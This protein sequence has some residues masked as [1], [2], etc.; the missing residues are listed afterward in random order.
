MQ[1]AELWVPKA[2]VHLSVRFG[3]LANAHCTFQ[4]FTI[5]HL[6]FPV[7]CAATRRSKRTLYSFAP[8]S[9]T[10]DRSV[11]IF[12]SPNHWNRNKKRIRSAPGEF[13][14]KRK[15]FRRNSLFI[16]FLFGISTVSRSDE[17]EPSPHVHRTPLMNCEATKALNSIMASL[18]LTFN[19]WLLS[20]NR[21][22]GVTSYTFIVH[23]IYGFSVQH[24][25]A[26]N[27]RRRG[28][29]QRWQRR[30]GEN[31]ECVRVGA[32]CGVFA[33]SSQT[34]HFCHKFCPIHYYDKLLDTNSHNR[35]APCASVIAVGY[36]PAARPHIHG[37][38]DVSGMPSNHKFNISI[39]VNALVPLS[40]RPDGSIRTQ[41][42]TMN[43]HTLDHCA[44]SSICRRTQQID[45]SPVSK[46]T[47]CRV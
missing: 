17:C 7:A 33:S 12:F 25:C 43:G 9:R 28:W 15:S 1:T 46:M 10:L 30:F 4:H 38:C 13:H 45:F 11:Y 41:T 47:A 39:Y 20:V 32:I 14:Y 31:V 3:D 23:L 37:A 24:L 21:S 42:H 34:N 5:W 40:Q 36:V 18:R 8:S 6:I 2:V 29:R 19:L 16:G 22:M 35:L 26:V 44:M 27:G